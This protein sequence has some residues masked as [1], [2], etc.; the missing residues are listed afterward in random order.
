MEVSASMLNLSEHGA[1]VRATVPFR[2]GQDVE[3]K[4]D[5]NETETRAYRVVWV[6]GTDPVAK[7]P[8]Y[9]AGLELCS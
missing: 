6:Q 8:I 7:Q 1:R 9:E 4:I 3:L 5:G 2:L